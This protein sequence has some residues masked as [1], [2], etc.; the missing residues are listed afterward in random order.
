MERFPDIV[1]LD[2]DCTRLRLVTKRAA[3]YVAADRGIP[4][5]DLMH[6]ILSVPDGDNLTCDAALSGLSIRSYS[7]QSLI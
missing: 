1:I 7:G 4:V 3:Q 5:D 2:A 6:C